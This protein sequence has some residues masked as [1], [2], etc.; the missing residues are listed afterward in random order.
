MSTHFQLLVMVAEVIDNNVPETWIQAEYPL[1]EYV[2]M[3]VAKASAPDE[4]I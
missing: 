4:T 2:K 1:L 3:N